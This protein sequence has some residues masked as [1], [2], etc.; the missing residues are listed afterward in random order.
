MTV[1]K[2]MKNEFLK[3]REGRIIGRLK[4]EWLLTR[5]GQPVA[6]YVSS[7]DKTMTREGRIVG[8]GDVRLFPLRKDQSKK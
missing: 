7:V 3:N 1:G 8:N 5:S 6:R 4:G 2:I